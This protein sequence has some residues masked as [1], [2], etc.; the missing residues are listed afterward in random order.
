M[1]PHLK[2]NELLH[3]SRY[4]VN[5]ILEKYEGKKENKK[6]QKFFKKFIVY[7]EFL[8][9][10]FFFL[11]SVCRFEITMKFYMFSYKNTFYYFN[12]NVTQA[13]VFV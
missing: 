11:K 3:I 4:I 1:R 5:N 2:V 7:H 13:C 8:F 10:S 9:A 6:L 12:F